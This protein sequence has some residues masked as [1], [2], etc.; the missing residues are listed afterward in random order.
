MNYICRAALAQNP[1]AEFKAEI[2][3]GSFLDAE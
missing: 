1:D 3:Q 2:F